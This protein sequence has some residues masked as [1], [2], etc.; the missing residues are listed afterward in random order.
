MSTHNLFQSKNKKKVYPC[1]PQFYYI[2]VGL[3]GYTWTCFPDVLD[4]ADFHSIKRDHNGKNECKF[5]LWSP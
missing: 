1:I 5:E 3:W 4:L 2:K